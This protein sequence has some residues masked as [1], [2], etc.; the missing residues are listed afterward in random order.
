MIEN[1][2]RTAILLIDLMPRIVATPTAPYDG[3][4]VVARATGLADALR[5]AGGLVVPVRVERPGVAEQPPGSGFVPEAAPRPGDLEIVKRTLGAFHRTGLDDALRARG[6]DT[7]LL[8]GIA[9][10]WGVES[11]GRIA[12]EH[13]Y[14]VIFVADAMTGLDEESHRFAVE[15]IFPRLGTVTSTAEVHAALSP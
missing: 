7:L 6:I 14:R 2:A 12:D 9:T 11:T 4:T 5:T 10:N 8:T 15:R 13:D 3:P 1:P